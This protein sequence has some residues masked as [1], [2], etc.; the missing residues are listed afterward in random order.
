M[1]SHILLMAMPGEHE[2][3]EK[4]MVLTLSLESYVFH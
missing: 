1:P 2:D 3:Q 4:K